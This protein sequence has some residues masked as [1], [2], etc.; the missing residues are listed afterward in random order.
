[1]DGMFNIN[2]YRGEDKKKEES[3]KKKKFDFI[4]HRD[5]TY[6]SLKEVNRFLGD[7][8]QISNYI[9]LYKILK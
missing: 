4:G 6:K 9:S 3:K 8:H 5:K 1:M 2:E 7:F